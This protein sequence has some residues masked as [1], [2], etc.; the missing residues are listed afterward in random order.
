M[1]NKPRMTII[2]GDN[3]NASSFVVN[4]GENLENNSST[5]CRQNHFQSNYS[6]NHF[7][8]EAKL[9]EKRYQSRAMSLDPS[10]LHKSKVS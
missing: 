8:Y 2:G 1:Y 4:S 9:H 6:P 10:S 3:F 5:D 7:N